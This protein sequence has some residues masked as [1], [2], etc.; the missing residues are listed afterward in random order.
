MSLKLVMECMGQGTTFNWSSSDRL[1]SNE[2]Q[3]N[4]LLLRKVEMPCY[5]TIAIKQL[6]RYL[7]EADFCYIGPLPERPLNLSSL[8]ILRQIICVRREEIPE[9]T[10]NNMVENCCLG[11]QNCELH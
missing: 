5:E 2:K 10:T 6:V 1:I 9:T 4:K 7:H 8:C 3:N 11:R